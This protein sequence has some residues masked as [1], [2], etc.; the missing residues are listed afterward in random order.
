MLIHGG[1]GGVG[2]FAVQFAKWAGAEVFTTVSARDRAFVEELGADRGIDYATE[3]FET[4]VQN[5]DLVFDLIGGETQDRSWSVLR[6]GGALISTV[7]AP[8]ATR[9]REAGITAKRYMC[10][11]DG[12]ELATIAR[13]ID[14]GKVKVTVERVFPA[15]RSGAGRTP[16]GARPRHRQGGAAGRLIDRRIAARCEGPPG[17]P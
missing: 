14:E 7:Q 6:R 8:D 13:L 3:R 2:P 12:G 11:P 9:A 4:L 5:A 1:G 15:G 17:T 10:E 16:S